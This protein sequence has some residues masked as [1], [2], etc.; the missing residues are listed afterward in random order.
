MGSHGR[1]HCPTVIPAVAAT[2]NQKYFLYESTNF[3]LQPGFTEIDALILMS[4]YAKKS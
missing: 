1:S 2:V 4:F 3:G